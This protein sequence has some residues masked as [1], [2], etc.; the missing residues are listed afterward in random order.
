MGVLDDLLADKIK[1][2]FPFSKLASITFIKKLKTIGITVKPERLDALLA[3]LEAQLEE[4]LSSD[5][6]DGNSDSDNIVI[7]DEW[8][9][10]LDNETDEV[11]TISFTEDDIQDFEDIYKD[12]LENVTNETLLRTADILLEGWHT[13]AKECLATERENNAQFQQKLL[14]VWGESL[15]LLEMLIS[16]SLDLGARFRQQ[17]NEEATQNQ[18]FVFEALTHLHARGCQV[19]G[20]TLTL[21][22]AGYADDAHARWRTLH[23]EFH[24]NSWK[25]CCKPL[26]FTL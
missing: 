14:E 10:N 19:A 2:A 7:E 11:V 23:E 20:A 13:S 16:I 6:V 1:E 17:N 21:L 22:K 4:K 5:K 15:E 8:F 9:L 12:T 26:P 25:R 18:D 24:K 3:Y